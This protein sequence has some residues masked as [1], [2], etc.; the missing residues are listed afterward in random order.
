MKY[1]LVV[2][3]IFLLTQ[4]L[5]VSQN[6]LS[7]EWKFIT[8]DDSAWSSANFDDGDWKSIEAGKSWESQGFAGYDGFAWYRQSVTPN[9]FLMKDAKKM[10]GFVLSLGNIDDCDEFYWNGVM[11]GSSGS[12][13]PNFKTAYNV[14]RKY[15]IPFELINWDKPNQIAIRVYDGTGMGGIVGPNISLAVP[16]FEN[17]FDI[18]PQFAR[19]DHLYLDKGAVTIPLKVTN[20]LPSNV[21]GKLIVEVKSDFGQEIKSETI[22]INLKSKSDKTVK[23]ELGELQPGFYSVALS[24]E[25]KGINKRKTFNIGVRPEEIISP[26]D[27]PDDFAAYWQKAKDELA[28]ID[29][30]FKLIK[31]DS[32]S[33]ATKEVFVVEMRSLGNVLIRGWYARPI[34]AGK[35]PAILHV[36][37]Y[38]TSPTVHW[39][40]SG[41]DM[42]SLV[43]NIRGHATSRDFINPGFPGYL[44]HQVEDKELYIYRGAYMDCLRAVDFL[45][46]QKEVDQSRV[47]VE[48]GSQGG[49]LSFATAALDNERINLCVPNVPFLSDFKDY[50]KVAFWP[51]SEFEA[52]FK[53]NPK[54]ED[55]IYET[56]SYIDIKNLA[57]WVKAPVIMS[58]GLVDPVC[59]PHINFA[60][61]NQ[62]TIEKSYIVYPE[63]GHSL[64]SEYHNTKYKYIKEHFNIQ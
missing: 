36:Q 54:S 14:D 22:S 10:G 27:R 25:G 33:T 20:K 40:Y 41:D 18:T 26:T 21:E 35:Y 42:I 59:P 49:A 46:A 47:A 52:Y 15:K 12:L 17:L 45:Y 29:P 19:E 16:G 37:G 31:Q 48:G 44:Q 24:V 50:F 38:S 2:G 62:L 60:A 6:L 34:K 8:G 61:Y 57:P 56:L 7:P 30:Q 9:K 32:L 3:L 55:T 63:A 5:C 51:G 4:N 1:Q 58:V 11:L 53:N 13:P 28:C 23:I 43:L 39:G 64:P